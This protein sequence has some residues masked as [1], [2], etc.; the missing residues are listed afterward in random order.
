MMIYSTGDGSTPRSVIVADFNN[1]NLSDIITVNSGHNNIGIRLGL[2]D[3]SFALIITY[4]TGDYS[5]PYAAAVGDFNNDGQLDIVVAEYGTSNADVFLG[6]GNGRFEVQVT[7]S[8]DFQAWPAW[9]TIGDFNND[10]RSDIAI[11]NYNINNVGIY[12]GLGNGSFSTVVPYSSG[13]GSSPQC[14]SISDFNEDNRLDIAV[15]NYATSNIVVLFGFGDGTFL[16]GK[17]YST[18]TESSPSSLAIVDVNNDQ[19]LDILVVNYMSNTMGIFLGYGREPF[20]G[21]TK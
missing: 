12:L 8:S 14:L 3:G 2:G 7:Y 10:N 19:R 21:V 17:V 9:V 15:A 11:A 1:D 13:D 18:G 20:A 16:L 6:Y 5:N 4:S